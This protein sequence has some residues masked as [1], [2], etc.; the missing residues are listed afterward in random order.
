MPSIAIGPYQYPAMALALFQP[1]ATTTTLAVTTASA[2][3]ALPAGDTLRLS[4]A[5]DVAISV[6]FGDGTVTAATTAMDILP[7]SA[8]VFR[9]PAGATHIAGIVAAGTA[10][11]KLT[12]GSG[13]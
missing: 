8:E 5:G 10:T 12:P 3:V 11:L 7:G 4:N 1:E 2:R 13:A 6:R 9:V